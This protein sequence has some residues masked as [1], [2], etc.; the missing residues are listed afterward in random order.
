MLRRVHFWCFVLVVALA[1]L[2]LGANRPWSWTLLAVLVGLLCASWPLAT[3]RDEDAPAVAPTRIA[4]PLALFG[5]V[6]LWALA[7][8]SSLPPESWAA[9]LWADALAALSTDEG[10]PGA[11]RVA[12]D[13]PAALVGVMRLL[14]YAGVFWLALQ[15]ARSGRRAHRLVE[16]LAVAAAVYAAYGLAVFLSGNETIL[17]MEKW[18]YANSLTSTF[19]NRNTYATYAGLGF[20][21]AVTAVAHRLEGVRMGRALLFHFRR[22]TALFALSGLVIALSLPETGS[23]AGTAS[24]ILGLAA[25]SGGLWATARPPGR[26]RTMALL[27][28]AAV[29][30]ALFLLAI[31]VITETGAVVGDFSDR[32]R[33]YELTLELLG[34]NP[35]TGLGL[36]SFAAAFAMIRPV[37]VALIWSE[38]HNTYLELAVE[39]GI[40]A[41]AALVSAVL[42][43]IARCLR[44][45][46]ARRRDAAYPILGV[47]ATVLVG[48]H[49]LFDFSLQIP[50]VTVTWAAILGAAV[51]QSWSTDAGHRP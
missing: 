33:T 4:V 20:L 48:A 9:P 51:A 7:Q 28:V 22:P 37:D 21:C 39:L 23:R 43:L 38:A 32:A 36:G 10:Q 18:A 26:A 50:A 16:A 15:H 24:A 27:I 17:W 30:A 25:L 19:V 8:T 1:P 40:P 41:T 31:G 13:S 44:G 11:A 2:P 12:L 34:R 42:W 46:V 3:A 47:A 5:G 29:V 49:A 14:C 45:A 6:I 35:W